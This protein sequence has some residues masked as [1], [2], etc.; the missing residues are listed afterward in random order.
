MLVVSI[1]VNRVHTQRD[2]RGNPINPRGDWDGNPSDLIGSMKEIG[3][4]EPIIVRPDANGGYLLVHGERRL[5][6]AKRLEWK[7]IP[8]H[9]KQS[10]GDPEQDV[11]NDIISMLAHGMTNEAYNVYGTAI[12]IDR[13]IRAG[14]SHAQIAQATGQK[15]IQNI[16]VLAD[17]ISGDMLSTR[18]ADAVRA[19]RIS[20]SALQR[21]ANKKHEVQDALLDAIPSG[22]I[23]VSNVIKFLRDLRSND[24][25]SSG[26][27]GDGGDCDGEGY[28]GDYDNDEMFDE[29][30]RQFDGAIAI[31]GSAF[32]T[33]EAVK[34]SKGL[35]KAQRASLER[36][37]TAVANLLK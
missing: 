24:T 22:Q 35:T 27:G 5:T 6:A 30:I 10:C 17:M 36:L 8:A 3:L 28:D 16:R 9:V 33:I 29:T 1:D 18:M 25:G 14:L 31:I 20:I 37:A 2:G 32:N 15:T 12:A 19:G 11:I 4:E 34:H 7:T 26:D 23:S 21:I 13:L